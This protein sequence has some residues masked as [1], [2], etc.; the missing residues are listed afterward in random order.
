MEYSRKGKM[1]KSFKTKYFMTSVLSTRSTIIFL[2]ITLLKKCE[3]H[4]KISIK[5]WMRSKEKG[6]THHTRKWKWR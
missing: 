2:T 3:T 6:W 1:H 5:L 4:L